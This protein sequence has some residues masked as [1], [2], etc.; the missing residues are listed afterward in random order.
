VKVCALMSALLVTYALHVLYT[1]PLSLE[2]V[3]LFGRYGV[4]L[5]WAL[6]GPVNLT[7]DLL[8]SKMGLSY[9]WNGQPSCQFRSLLHIFCF[10]DK[11]SHGRDRLINWKAAERYVGGKAYNN[12]LVY[13]EG[14]DYLVLYRCQSITVDIGRMWA[15]EPCTS[16][17]VRRRP[18]HCRSACWLADPRWS[19][20]RW[21]HSDRKQVRSTLANRRRRDSNARETEPLC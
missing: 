2:F 18:G 5:V 1:L 7:F 17:A 15:S 20:T 21:R 14:H 10:R 3:H 4:F 12:L 9:M 8:I 19:G 16:C 6:C 13:S 11:G